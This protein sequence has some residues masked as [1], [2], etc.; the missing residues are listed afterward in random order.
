M[1]HFQHGDSGLTPSDTC[2]L[3]LTMTLKCKHSK[4]FLG[5]GDLKLQILEATS[6]LDQILK[7]DAVESAALNIQYA[8]NMQYAGSRQ[9]G[10]RWGLQE[11]GSLFGQQNHPLL[12]AGLCRY[13][14]HGGSLCWVQ[15][16]QKGILVLLGRTGAVSQAGRHATLTS[17]LLPPPLCLL[18]ADPFPG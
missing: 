14:S 13:R 17:P 1:C 7:D 5:G 8:L 11:V 6:D 18:L 12:P 3:V 16:S 9:E 15:L 2:C 4:E 10:K